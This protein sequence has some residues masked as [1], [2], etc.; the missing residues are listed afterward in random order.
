[1]GLQQLQY[2]AKGCFLPG[3][4]IATPNGEQPIETLKPGDTVI[5]FNEKTKKT[6]E[7]KIG[8]VDVLKRRVFYTINGSVHATAEHPFYTDKGIVEVKNLTT[9]HKLYDRDHKEVEVTSIEKT[10]RNVTVYNLLDVE[11][12]NNY[13]ADGFLVHNKGCFLEGTPIRTPHGIKRIEDFKPGDE[14]LSFNEETGV[15]EVAKV[16]RLDVLAARRYY[17]INYSVN[18]TGEHPFYTKDGIKEV[19]DLRQ[20][21]ILITKGGEEVVSNIRTFDRDVV[22][23]NLINVE[24]NHNY[25]AADFLVHNKGCFL[26]GT[27]IKTPTGTKQIQKMRPNDVVVSYNEKTG[28]AEYSTVQSIQ[29]LQASGYYILNNNIK[30]TGTHPM[31]VEGIYGTP[32]VVEVKNLKI[33]NRLITDA[34]TQLI[35]KMEYIQKPVTVYNLINVDP[36]HNYYAEN[37]LVHNKGGGGCFLA[38]TQITAKTGNKNIEDIKAGDQIWT[39]NE[40]TH[41]TE[42]ATVGELQTLEEPAHY[43]IN[44]EV[45]TTAKHP[46]YTTDGI[47]TVEELKIGDQLYKGFDN[48]TTIKTI[49][50]VE[51][52]VTVY[53]LLNVT[54]NH[55]YLANGYLVHNKG[56]VGGG[57]RSSSGGGHSNTG[58]SKSGSSSS[59]KSSGPAPGTSKATPGSKIKTADGKE[60]Q[61]SA[62]KPASSQ[63]KSSNGVVGDNGYTPRYTNGYTPPPGSVVYNRDRDFMDYL[64]WIYLFSQDSPAKDQQVIVQPDGKEVQA[65]PVQEGV[66][67]LA[68]LNWILLIAIIA[69]II[70]GIVWGVNKYA[71]R[72]DPPK[73]KSYGGYY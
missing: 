22:I 34:G 2:F 41:I 40:T 27:R 71:T 38:G 3:T 60:V 35:L 11:P 61:S 9:K 42:L 39:L 69:G 63:Y 30:V 73:R 7:S 49:E 50:Y 19:K 15:E 4:M 29:V 20:G 10:S 5:S 18:A 59:S 62:K 14:V 1:M 16:E 13:F 72:N 33:G 8:D 47:K 26:A 66:D 28:A 70:G 68:V 53:N 37:Y 57:G 36:N 44:G 31:Y 52:T 51:G 43:V 32:E 46:F 23:Y 48:K 67:G 65:Q 64:P 56:G 17:N 6:Q 12:N 55:N 45:K 54:P 21:D 24:P 58:G 25:Y